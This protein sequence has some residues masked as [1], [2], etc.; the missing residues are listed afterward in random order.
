MT[1][2]HTAV[3]HV[4]DGC[5]KVASQS[6]LLNSKLK[7]PPSLS[8]QRAQQ[9]A[10]SGVAGAGRRFFLTRVIPADGVS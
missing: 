2:V 10:R 9:R 7:E 8:L 1:T 6:R 5:M 3:A 4:I